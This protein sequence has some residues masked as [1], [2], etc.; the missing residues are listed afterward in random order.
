MEN[1]YCHGNDGFFFNL[2]LHED[3]V[4]HGNEHNEYLVSKQEGEEYMENIITQFSLVIPDASH[5]SEY[6]RLMDKWEKLEAN[7]QPELMRRYNKEKDEYASYAKWLAWCKD[8]RTT[9]SMLSTHVPCSLH[10]LIN[11]ESE[12]YGAIAINHANTHR[13]HLHAGI[14]PWHRSKGYGTMMLRLALSRC[15][16]MGM[17]AVQIVPHRDN[18]GAVKTI[19]GNGGVWIEDFC[20][21]GI[22][23]S[24]FE[25]ILRVQGE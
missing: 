3:D 13:G 5:E 4:S 25:I 12:I 22:W 8:D 1:E 20:E 11:H 18:V 14:V 23:S 9:G 10:F 16:E 7:I 21:E 17:R 15:R 2:C 24:R 6:V 19:L